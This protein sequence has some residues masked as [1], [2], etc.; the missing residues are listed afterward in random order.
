MKYK[1]IENDGE[2]DVR[3]FYVMGMGTKSADSHTIGQFGTGNK[4]G[5]TALLRD[6]NEVT[7]MSGLKKIRFFTRV[8]EFRGSDFRHVCIKAGNKVIETSMTIEMGK[9]NWNVAQG[10]K[11]IVSNALDEGGMEIAESNKI[12]GAKGKTR[13]FFTNSRNVQDFFS[14][15]D[16]EFTFNRKPIFECEHGRIYYPIDD[17]GRVY[18]KG[19][20]V[21]ESTNKFVYD[22]DMN[23]LSVGENRRSSFYEV[24]WDVPTLISA[25]PLEWKKRIFDKLVEYDYGESEF[26]MRYKDDTD[27]WEEIVGDTIVV[28]NEEHNFYRQKLVSYSVAVLPMQWVS[29]FRNGS[30]RTIQDVL[31]RANLKGW[32]KVDVRD[33]YVMELRR[34]VVEFV[35]DMGYELSEEEIIFADNNQEG[36]PLGQLIDDKIYVNLVAVR[37]GFDTFLATVFEELFHRLSRAGDETREFQNFILDELMYHM[38]RLRIARK[39]V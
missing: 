11:E 17:K 4:Y 25:L 23:E 8:T 21:F 26:E 1:V 14:G 3:S 13:V 37:G 32:E 28:T 2:V 36:S 6:G 15:I 24:K 20:L 31:S 16:K 30:I 18:R 19:V 22:Y 9:L 33:P 27:G 34:E 5:I 29:F 12:S 7:V 35:N 39:G 38:K 10:I